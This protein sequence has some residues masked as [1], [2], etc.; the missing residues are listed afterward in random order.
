VLL[1]GCGL[2]A[3]SLARLRQIDAGV[4]IQHMLTMQMQLS[5]PRYAEPRQRVRFFSEL[6]DRL[7]KLPAVISAS[8]VSRLPI[9]T[10]GLDTRY[11]N[12][13]STDAHRFDPN[14]PTRQMAHTMSADLD[15]F[16]TMGIA[17]RKGRDFSRADVLGAPP[18]AIVNETLARDFFPDGDALGRRILFG[19]PTASGTDP[20]MTIVGVISDVRTGALDLPPAPQFYTPETQDPSNQVVVVVRTEGDPKNVIRTALVVA[21]RLDPEQVVT[22]VRTMEQHVESTLGQPRFRAMLISSFAVSALFLAG[23]GIYGV[24]AYAVTQRTKE[25]GIRSALG[26]DAGRIIATVLTDGLRPI[27]IGVAIGVGGSLMLTR[28]LAGILYEVKPDDPI[29]IVWSIALLIGLGIVACLAPAVAASR[30]D[31]VMALREE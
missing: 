25:F 2:L 17:L 22:D 23:V 26:A 16:Q 27:A 10:V 7:T 11:G 18:V 3:K 6:Q 13:F 15:Y 12:P 1:I 31:P 21:R 14:A 8:E 28:F 20:W 24:V 19:A 4:R 29:T 5:G 30:L 9:D